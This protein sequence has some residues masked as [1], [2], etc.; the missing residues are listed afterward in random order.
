MAEREICIS[1][2]MVLAGFLLVINLLPEKFWNKLPFMA[3]PGIHIGVALV[4]LLFTGGL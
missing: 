1:I 2:I 3:Y 4:M